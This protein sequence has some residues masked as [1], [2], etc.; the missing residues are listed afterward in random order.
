[1]WKEIETKTKQEDAPIWVD[2]QAINDK[3]KQGLYILLG[4]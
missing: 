3:A 1:M 4:D 2:L